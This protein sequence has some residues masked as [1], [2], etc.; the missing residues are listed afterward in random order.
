MLRL[1]LVTLFCVGVTTPS[2]GDE[3]AV[4]AGSVETI[5]SDAWI[6]TGFD[7]SLTLADE[8]LSGDFRIG[9]IALLEA[10]QVFDDVRI[11]C[12][13]IVLTSR[14]T[15]CAD[16]AFNFVIPGIGRQTI[17]GS[18]TYDRRSGIAEIEL[19]RVAIASGHIR[20]SIT[21]SDDNVGARYSGTG[22]Q[23]TGLLEVATNFSD[24]FADYSVAGLADLSGSFS[25]PG[26]APMQVA[27][28]AD[29]SDTSLANNAGT[30]AADGVA[31]KLEMDITLGPETTRFT[32]SF[33]SQQGEAYLEPVYA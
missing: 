14:N 17:P 31:G 15:Q 27:F 12:G 13:S 21:A 32:L 23:L 4:V 11:D 19:S 3:L 6:V 20:C 28:I 7:Y 5:S 25:A 29:L 24:A 22:L 26:E 16:A 33:D 10:D 18:F 30:V 1:V 9:R 2:P 8:G